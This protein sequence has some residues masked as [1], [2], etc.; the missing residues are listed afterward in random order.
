MILLRDCLSHPLHTQQTLT[1]IRLSKS[2]IEANQCY[3]DKS[4]PQVGRMSLCLIPQTRRKLSEPE[5]ITQARTK[6]SGKTQTITKYKPQRGQAIVIDTLC[7]V[8][9]YRRN[10]STQGVLGN[11]SKMGYL[12]Q[13]KQSGQS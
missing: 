5:R 2:E 13:G 9:R 6:G 8:L 1:R 11:K 7:C 4:R 10:L 3:L 12:R